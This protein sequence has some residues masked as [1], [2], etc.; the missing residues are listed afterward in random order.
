MMKNKS[1]LLLL[2]SAFLTLGIILAIAL[3][4]WSGDKSEEDSLSIVIGIPQDLENSLDPHEMVAAGTKEVLFNLFEGLVKPDSDGNLYPAVASDV[5]MLDNGATYL[6][7]LRKGVTFHDGSEVTAQDVIYSIKRCADASNQLMLVPAYLNIEEINIVEEDKIEIKL[8]EADT[9]F[10]AFMTTAIIPESNANPSQNPIG[11]GPYMYVSRS[12]QEKIVIKRY[13]GYWGEPAH[14]VNVTFKV[15]SNSDTIVM[16][17]L[18]GSIDMFVRVTS[19][20][21]DELNDDFDIIEGT[22]NLVQALYLNNEVAPFDDI[23]VRRALAYA[24][25]QQAVMDMI[26]EGKGVEIGSS[27][28][29]AFGKYYD[30]SLADVYNTNIEEAKKLLKEAGYE[31]GLSFTMTVPSNYKQHVDTAQ[32]LAEQFKAIGVDAKIQ[33]IDWDSWVSDVYVGGNYEST[34]V[35]VDASSLTASAL[36]ERFTTDAEKNF[37]NF[38]NAEYDEAFKNARLSVTDEEQIAY[39]KEC[40]KI[41]TDEAANVYIQDMPELVALNKKYAGYEFYPLYIMDISKLYI[42]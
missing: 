10:L 12:P 22:M 41:L 21:A 36:L 29:P 40:Q 20:Q 38:S 42:K 17:L 11:T 32:V 3:T 1:V 18:G 39:Y 37:I 6:F 15:V 8:R 4:S 5:E 24:V 16:N 30:A 23:R 26:S 14:I 33:L 7:T 34:V 25:N 2:I 13:N 31:D 28:F 27:M 19:A 9:E 35:G